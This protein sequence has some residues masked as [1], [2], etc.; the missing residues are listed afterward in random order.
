MKHVAAVTASA[1]W[2]IAATTAAQNRPVFELVSVRRSEPTSTAVAGR[3]GP[4]AG[5]SVLPGGRVEVRAQTVVDVARVA[6]GF[7]QVDPSRGMVE[8]GPNWLWNDRFDITAAVDHQWTAPPPGSTVP[9]ELRPMLRALLEDRFE[10]RARI[11]MKT[12][13]V[14]ALRLAKPGTPG[15]GLRPSAAGCLGPFTNPTAGETLPRCPFAQT[16]HR[17]QADSVTMPEAAQLIA[18]FPG[19]FVYRGDNSRPVFIDQTTLPGKYDLLLELP[20][21]AP[22]LPSSSVQADV[23]SLFIRTAVETQLGLTLEPTRVPIPML[24]IDQ[25]RKPRLD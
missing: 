16:R 21:D 4:R 2:L 22:A 13:Q 24:V 1:L 10:L 20:A 12:M 7:E 9:A 3:S 5:F 25:A 23:R 19:L 6:F 11:D 8:A 18:R 15:P 17:L 14:T